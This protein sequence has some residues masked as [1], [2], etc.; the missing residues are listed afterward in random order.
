[1]TLRTITPRD[2]K[3]LIDQGAIL[4][5]IREGD[6]YARER[7]AGARH[8]ALSKLDEAQLAAPRGQP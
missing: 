6:E 5:D 8:L 3:R 4:V 2:A 7:I 1:M